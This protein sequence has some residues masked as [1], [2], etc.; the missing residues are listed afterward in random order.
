MVCTVRRSAPFSIM[1][2]A[3]ECRNECGPT[4]LSPMRCKRLRTICQ[5]R[6]RVS[7]PLCCPGKSQGDESDRGARYSR[8]A[9][10][11]R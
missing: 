9:S 7:C 10:A 2:V 1:C 6:C 11:H 4:L 8:K 5:M 3:Q